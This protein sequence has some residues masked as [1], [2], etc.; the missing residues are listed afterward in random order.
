MVE[1]SR[2]PN[3]P[4]P[5][6]QPRGWAGWHVLFGLFGGLMWLLALGRRGVETGAAAAPPPP[7]EPAG[8]LPREVRHPDG[9]IEHPAVSFERKDVSARGIYLVILAT[10]L[11]AV[12]HYWIVWWF[13]NDY[14]NYE[15]AI[16]RSPYPLAPVPSQRLPAEPRLEQLDRLEGIQK[17]NVYLREESKEQILNSGGPTAEP[18]YVHIPIEQA[19]K[20]VVQQLPVR[21]RPP[22]QGPVKDKGLVAGGE[23]NSGRLFRGGTR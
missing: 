12:F 5:N 23:P 17:P 2:D 16:K 4:P 10:A 14:N 3:P 13:F 21:Q 18:G 6:G 8:P 20:Q 22:P 11:L 7:P 15:S 19:M 1:R 9:R